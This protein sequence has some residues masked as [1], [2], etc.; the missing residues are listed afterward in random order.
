MATFPSPSS[1][2]SSNTSQPTTTTTPSKESQHRETFHLDSYDTLVKVF[3]KT[4][5]REGYVDRVVLWV[6]GG[7]G[8]KSRPSCGVDW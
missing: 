8:G 7:V 4:R 1:S 5:K 3:Q 6:P 2:S